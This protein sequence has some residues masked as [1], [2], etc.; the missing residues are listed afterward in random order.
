MIVSCGEA[1]IDFV[2]MAGA[3]GTPGYRPCP[4][5]SPC[6]VA[7]AVSRLG[8]PAGFLG[9]ISTDFFGD[10]LMATL[11]ENGVDCSLVRRADQPSTLGFVSLDEREPDYAFFSNGAADR[12]LEPADLPK[13]LPAGIACLQ[14][15][16]I[17]LMQEPAA[18]TL[19]T[20][21]RRESGRRVLSLDP[22][23]RPRL[24][25]D[26]ESYRRRLE[27]WIAL[28]D[29]VKVSRADLEWL[30][31]GIPAAE[32]ATRWFRTGPALVVVT[33]GEEG[34]FAVSATGIS[35]PV[36]GTA[37]QVVDTVGAGDT[38][39]G[40]LLAW[41]Y[42]GGLLNR[43]DLRR[44]TPEQEVEALSFANKAAAITCSRRGNDPPR[45]DELEP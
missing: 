19:E 6:N 42:H 27:D 28:V 40:A 15:G 7:V 14:F 11:R 29:I 12:S 26:R 45:M 1:L 17:S 44:L 34:A 18:T 30:Y 35:P 25:P 20:L 16:S 10:L 13:P 39:H 33:G 22:N 36:R 24:I 21:M 5:G 4:G 41:L 2:P 9:R 3:D 43:D 37:V 32:V 38:F 8:A 31:P 23:V